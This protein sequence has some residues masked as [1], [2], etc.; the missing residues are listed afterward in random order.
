[1]N[2][3]EGELWEGGSQKDKQVKDI[4]ACGRSQRL[5]GRALISKH[6]SNKVPI[7]SSEPIL[8]N[9]H[10][11]QMFSATART[12]KIFTKMLF[13]CRVIIFPCFYEATMRI[14]NLIWSQWRS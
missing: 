8:Q 2:S 9:A 14:R 12:S 11:P 6:I 4:V 13:G 7:S 10:I 3:G 1:M 5:L